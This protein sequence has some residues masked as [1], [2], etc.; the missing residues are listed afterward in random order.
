MLLN[1]LFLLFA[2]DAVITVIA[3]LVLKK[4]NKAEW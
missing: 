4:S 2:T 1:D 3:M